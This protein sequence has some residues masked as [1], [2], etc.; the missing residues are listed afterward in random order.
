M[1]AEERAMSV[2]YLPHK[3]GDLSKWGIIK[4]GLWAYMQAEPNEKEDNCWSSIGKQEV[5]HV[6]QIEK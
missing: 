1:R 2:K 5:D 3:Y 4:T 6:F